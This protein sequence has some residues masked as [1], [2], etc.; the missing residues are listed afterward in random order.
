[1]VL[2]S[3]G[4]ASMAAL[5]KLSCQGLPFFVVVLGRSVV[6]AAVALGLLRWRGAALRATNRPL[7][8][9]RSLTG[10]A[11]M[12]CY[13]YAISQVPLA[14]AVTLQYTSPLFVALLSGLTVRERVAPRT[15][16]AIGVAFGGVLLIVGP[17][18]AGFDLGALWALASAVLAALAYL[19]VRGLSPTDAPETIVLHFAVFALVASTPGLWALERWPT[20]IE[21]AALVGVGLGASVGQ[22]FMTHAYRVAEAAFVSAFS[23]VAV[24]FSAVFGF[25]LFDEVPTA[26]AATGAALVVAAGAAL[27]LSRPR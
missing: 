23:Y 19:A 22:V 3:L 12:A 25:V 9:A 24:L 18:L 2:A 20:A 10:F 4:F 11:A 27:S 17:D 15:F 21:L 6:V 5:V 7:M 26:A 16:V 13:F 8:L 1:M 14:T